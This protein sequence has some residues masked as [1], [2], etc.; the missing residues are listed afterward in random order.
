MVGRASPRASWTHS[1]PWP[2]GSSGA[3][4]HQ[5]SCPPGSSGA[6]PHQSSCSP[7]AS[8]A[9]PHQ[10]SCPRLLRSVASPVGWWGERPR[11]PVGFPMPPGLPARQEPHPT[12]PVAPPARQEPRPTKA[13][14][15]RLVGSLAPPRQ[16]VPRLPPGGNPPPAP[17]PVSHSWIPQA[18]ALF[19]QAAP[20]SFDM[21]DPHSHTSATNPQA[22]PLNPQA[23]G[24]I[25]QVRELVPQGWGM[26]FHVRGG[27]F[28]PSAPFLQAH[29][30]GFET[31]PTRGETWG[32]FPQA[33]AT[34]PQGWGLIPQAWGFVA[35][36]W[37][38]VPQGWGRLFW[39][40]N[41]F[42]A[43]ATGRRGK[44]ARRLLIINQFALSSAD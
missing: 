21:W 12:K 7:G 22:S 29:L 17:A 14:A 18:P 43:G 19:P 8:G 3:S 13:V 5:N 33:S 36:G 38:I 35:E 2:P 25:P 31:S 16:P 10:G 42:P 32:P 24:I 23:W 41:D 27:V 4:P 9:S 44:L 1:A 40:K 39:R 28:Q 20:K 26:I 6:S 15:P 30:H 37:G 34:N 11:E